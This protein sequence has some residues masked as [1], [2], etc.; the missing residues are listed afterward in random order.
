MTEWYD[1]A[2]QKSFSTDS[3]CLEFNGSKD[4]DGY[5][6][7]K[8]GGRV[9]KLHR[10]S[11]ERFKGE[12]P[13]DLV[14]RHTCDN[15]SCWNPEHLIVGTH[16]ENYQDMVSR[17]RDNKAKGSSHGRAKLTEDQV[18]EI[19]LLLFEGVYQKDIA[20]KFCV[21]QT[22]ISFIKLNKIWGI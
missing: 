4:K 22:L 18:K 15:P 5:G 10:L 13:E 14:I 3:G 16:K 2:L 11:Y 20:I 7:V 9:R 12:I 21:N 1:R 8:T 6:V 19:R 17:G